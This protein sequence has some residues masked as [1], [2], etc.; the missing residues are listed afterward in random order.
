[1]VLS[2]CC[3]A[4]HAGPAA[5]QATSAAHQGGSA[6]DLVRDGSSCTMSGGRGRWTDLQV[7]QVFARPRQTGS[8]H[9]DCRADSE[10]SRE[11]ELGQVERV[12]ASRFSAAMAPKRAG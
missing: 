3:G 10:T 1:M 5:P 2:L 12:S 4:A 8:R 11:Q 7:R 9:E 6:R